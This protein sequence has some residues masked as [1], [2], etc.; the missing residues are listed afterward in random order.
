MSVHLLAIDSLPA[1][2]LGCYGEHRIPTPHFDKLA[3]QSVVCHLYLKNADLLASLPPLSS[4]LQTSHWQEPLLETATL[5]AAA[6]YWL[7]EEEMALIFSD[8]EEDD[9]DDDDRT[10]AGSRERLADRLRAEQVQLV[11]ASAIAIAHDTA[12]GEWLSGM[13]FQ[14]GD[15]LVI[16]GTTGDLRRLPEQ[17]P[18]WQAS[19]SEPMIH[20]PL[21][22]QVI[23]RNHHHRVHELV[24]TADL[25]RL[26]SQ[27]TEQGSKAIDQWS[28]DLQT[29]E[30]YWKTST[31]SA[32]RTWDWLLIKYHDAN[33]N[34]EER[35][36]PQVVLFRKPEDHWEML[37]V[38]TQHPDLVES[39]LER[40][41]E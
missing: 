12:L 17:R 3:S 1:C 16:V 8:E 31:L 15:V 21:L 22:I 13:P 28:C 35:D 10:P 36:G 23:G 6:E 9:D 40:L 2:S 18:E 39:L 20:L 38:A 25:V 32:I 19:L 34:E 4:T 30:I 11:E 7:N 33:D 26:I 14:E 24:E 41:R 37:D 29:Q 5:F 27:L